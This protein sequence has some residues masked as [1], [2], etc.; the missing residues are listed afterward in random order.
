[1]IFVGRKLNQIIIWRWAG[2]PGQDPP[3]IDFKAILALLRPIHFNSF[4]LFNSF[5]I[6]IKT[7]TADETVFPFPSHSLTQSQRETHLSAVWDAENPIHLYS[8]ISI[9]YSYFLSFLFLN[10]GISGRLGT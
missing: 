7:A 10:P 3:A 4:P 6:S 1:M 5:F 8:F 2:C 9:M